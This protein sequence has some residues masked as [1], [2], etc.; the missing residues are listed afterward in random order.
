M[1]VLPFKTKNMILDKSV[2]QNG[3]P[4]L[5]PVYYDYIST[6]THLSFQKTLKNQI[7]ARF[8]LIFIKIN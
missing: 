2:V 8:F 7:I 1:T 3:L 4:Y 5:Y 6:K